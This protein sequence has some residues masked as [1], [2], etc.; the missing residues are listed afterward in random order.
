M[1]QLKINVREVLKA[2]LLRTKTTTQRKAWRENSSYVGDN[3]VH[4]FKGSGSIL[5][6]K[7]LSK[8][9]KY[10]VGE[11][12]EMVWTGSQSV[13]MTEFRTLNLSK[14]RANEIMKMYP[15]LGYIKVDDIDKITIE[16]RNDDV[17]L[18]EIEFVDKGY[19]WTYKGLCELC[20][21]NIIDLSKTE[22]FKDPETMFKFL[23]EYAPEIKERPM[24]FWLIG[25]EWIE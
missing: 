23:E 1:K 11:T 10:E 21:N 8:P 16:R 4:L 18:Y 15:V 24:P 19:S 3:L 9:C 12:L 22:G 20:T 17:G 2:A 25:L 13:F 6:Y 14:E 5:K 7:T